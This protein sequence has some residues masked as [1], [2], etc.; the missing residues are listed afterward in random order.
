MRLIYRH[1]QYLVLIMLFF[2]SGTA[3]GQP[4]S[5][6]IW[7]S[8]EM[9]ANQGLISYQFTVDTINFLSVD[10]QEMTEL[11]IETNYGPIEFESVFDG[12]T[13]TRFGRGYLYSDEDIEMFVVTGGTAKINGRV[14]DLSSN[15]EISEFRPIPMRL[16]IAKKAK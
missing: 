3:W 16:D 4:P 8:N 5:L 6:E 10:G 1:I 2:F 7:H 11:T 12:S 13:A 14:Q 15:I 9:P